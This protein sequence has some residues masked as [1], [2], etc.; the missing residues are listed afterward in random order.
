MLL[1]LIFMLAVPVSL[2]SVEFQT[3]VLHNTPIHLAALMALV[4]TGGQLGRLN[5]DKNLQKILIIGLLLLMAT[6][7]VRAMANLPLELPEG[8]QLDRQF[9]LT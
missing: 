9:F 6:S 3:R 5:E 8:V 2:G 1:S 7:S 4:W